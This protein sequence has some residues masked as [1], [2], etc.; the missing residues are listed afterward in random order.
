MKV[1]IKLPDWGDVKGWTDGYQVFKNKDGKWIIPFML[2]TLS[3]F[4]HT[5]DIVPSICP[6]W[7]YKFRLDDK[8]YWITNEF[9]DLSAELLH[10]NKEFDI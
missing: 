7:D 9:V 1:N 8:I 2:D 3:S 6:K 10:F 5:V 4:N